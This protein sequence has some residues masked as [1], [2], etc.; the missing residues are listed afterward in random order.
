MAIDISINTPLTEAQS[1]LVGKIG[2]MKT[3]LALP[4]LNFTTIPRANQMSLFDYLLK[5]LEVLGVNP[6]FLFDVFIEKIV[7][8]TVMIEKI[9]GVFATMSAKKGKNLQNQTTTPNPNQSLR[10]TI[11]KENYE[12]LQ[13][14]IGAEMRSFF[15]VM[16][17]KI[18]KDLTMMIFGES[19][20][21]ATNAYMSLPVTYNSVPVNQG[22]TE[23]TKEAVCGAELF[24][25]SNNPSVKNEDLEYNRIQLLQKM[26]KGEVKYKVSCQNIEITLPENPQMIFEGGGPNIVPGTPTPTQ[27]P[28]QSIKMLITHVGNQVQNKNEEKNA[29]SV[30]ATFSK[31]F[32]EKII[33]YAPTIFRPIFDYVFAYLPIADPSILD[34]QGGVSGY[35][36]YDKSTMLSSCCDI[37]NEPANEEKKEMAYNLCNV[38]LKILLGI[39]LQF[40]IKKIKDL[41]VQ[42]FA[43]KALEKLKRK[44]EKLTMRFKIVNQIKDAADTAKKTAQLAEAMSSVSHILDS[45]GIGI[46]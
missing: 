45:G 8:E 27:T 34:V 20:N 15:K 44:Q 6:T 31:N 26:K 4:K 39:L 46:I 29:N 17:M 9:L 28:A 38:L 32:V 16:K 35:Y 21:P 3:L 14:K 36:G 11:E 2:S 40:I 12:Y 1:E 33:Q 42:Y 13:T 22:N 5:I 25:L 19:T 7:D 30:S 23:F 43:R 24:S 10:K 41:A 37:L 18:V